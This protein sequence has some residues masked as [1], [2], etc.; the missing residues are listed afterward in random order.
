MCMHQ[1]CSSV[2][3]AGTWLIAVAAA[4]LSG[5]SNRALPRVLTGNATWMA[6]VREMA[7]SGTLPHRLASA[8]GALQRAA[9]AE[10][11]ACIPQYSAA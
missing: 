10:V 8:Y 3:M 11:G 4:G 1:V 2:A 6:E 9:D 7:S 5:P